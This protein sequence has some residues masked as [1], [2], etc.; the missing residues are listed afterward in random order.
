MAK[1][2]AFLFYSSDFLTGTNFM[3][4]EQVGKYIRLLCF[5]H[6]KGRLKKE[7]MFNICNPEDSEILEKFK[8]DENGNY[9]NERLENEANRRK[10]YSDS[11]KRNRQKK[12]VV[13]LDEHMSNI[14]KTY[15]EHMETA[16]ATTN[17]NIIKNKIKNNE[18]KFKI[19]GFYDNICLSE[20]QYKK[21]EIE[22]MHSETVKNLIEELSQNV[23][24]G[25]EPK[26]D[27]E[28]NHFSRLRAYWQ[29]R[30]K[31][32]EKFI[33]GCKTNPIKGGKDGSYKQYNQ[34]QQPIDVKDSEFGKLAAELQTK[35]GLKAFRENRS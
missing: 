22:I 29:F 3:N 18:D 32:P 27:G 24:D 6:Q 21:L 35:G 25:K 1:D 33:E 19:F 12:E 28:G 2:P 11:R 26:F 10:S 8:I 23:S 13:V 20:Q 9:Y 16:T 14:C 30:R 4:D 15:D 17:I 31:N 34:P 5:Q 7:H